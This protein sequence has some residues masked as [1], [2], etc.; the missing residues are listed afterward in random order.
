MA[1]TSNSIELAELSLTLHHLSFTKPFQPSANLRALQQRTIFSPSHPSRHST[2]PVHI[3]SLSHPEPETNASFILSSPPIDSTATPKKRRRVSTGFVATPVPH[4]SNTI[5]NLENSYDTAPGV[6]EKVKELM[7]VTK[8]QV[9]QLLTSMTHI[10]TWVQLDHPDIPR[11]PIAD[12]I[13][14]VEKWGA[15]VLDGFPAYHAKRAQYVKE[16][17]ESESGDWLEAIAELDSVQLWHLQGVLWE[18]VQICGIFYG[19]LESV[20]AK[21]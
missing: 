14:T 9:T 1:V 16:N 19:E 15:D 3:D 20:V 6:N 7:R 2:R 18:V 13:S 8:R 17:K 10:K 4:P 5:S 12:E 11:F 21:I